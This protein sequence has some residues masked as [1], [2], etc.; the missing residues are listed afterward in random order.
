M[1]N[2]FTR[3]LQKGSMNPLMA[4]AMG[5]VIVASGV[6]VSRQ[7]GWL[8]TANTDAPSAQTMPNSASTEAPSSTMPPTSNHANASYRERER[9]EREERERN[10]MPYRTGDSLHT[11]QDVSPYQQP[12]GMTPA[13]LQTQAPPPC[14]NCGVIS[15]IREETVAGSKDSGLGAV[16]GG[17]AGGVL[18]HQMGQGNG[19]TVATVLGA[20]GGM[21][22][23]NKVEEHERANKVWIVAL[24]MENGSRHEITLQNQPNLAQGEPVRVNGTQIIPR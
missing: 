4:I 23:G 3:V 17:V 22:A 15:S 7:M 19:R 10:H 13:A 1:R 24:Q 5:S 20:L 12:M 9:A 16:A 21:F 8:H 11:A 2:R 6:V 14:P 18:G